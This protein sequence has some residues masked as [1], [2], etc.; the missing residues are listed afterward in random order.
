MMDRE[1]IGRY[2][3]FVA[4]LRRAGV[5]AELYLGNPKNNLSVQFKY[6]DRRNSPCVVIQGSSEREN[7]RGPIVVVKDL[8]LGKVAAGKSSEDRDE[9]LQQ[10]LVAQFAVVEDK[11]V[12]TVL[13][14]LRRYE[15]DWMPQHNDRHLR[16]L[17]P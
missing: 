11:L 16:R 1:E 17:E 2:Q 9:Y 15:I 12:E 7:V 8:I 14:V 10:Q 3:K 4:D 6:A 5:R 13:S